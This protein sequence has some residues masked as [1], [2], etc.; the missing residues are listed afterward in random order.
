MKRMKVVQGAWE[1]KKRERK[2]EERNIYVEIDRVTGFS[3]SFP[4]VE[5]REIDHQ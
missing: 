3:F 4:S 1:R 2:R 5:T